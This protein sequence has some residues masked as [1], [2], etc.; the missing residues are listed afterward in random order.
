MQTTGGLIQKL[1]FWSDM[2]E[3]IQLGLKPENR[4][5]PSSPYLVAKG[6]CRDGICTVYFFFKMGEWV[7]GRCYGYYGLY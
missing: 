4:S 2:F 3:L 5:L 6:P 1:L 7:D